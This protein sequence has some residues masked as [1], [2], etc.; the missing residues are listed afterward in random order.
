MLVDRALGGEVFGASFRNA[1]SW[2]N[3]RVP[4]T[5]AI[6]RFPTVDCLEPE[7]R[8]RVDLT[9]SLHRLAMTAICAILPF[10]ARVGTSV[11]GRTGAFKALFVNGRSSRLC[12]IP[13]T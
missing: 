6:R 9:R 4:R 12:D 2:R 3:C 7:G 11:S 5:S 1:R 10:P 13:S 8:L